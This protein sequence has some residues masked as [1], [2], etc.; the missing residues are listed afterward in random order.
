MGVG[1]ER[2]IPV[3]PKTFLEHLVSDAVIVLNILLPFLKN[4]L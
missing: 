2:E 4:T 3:V 1:A